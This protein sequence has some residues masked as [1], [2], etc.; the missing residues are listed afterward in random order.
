M[1]ELYN[2]VEKEEFLNTIEVEE[3]KPI[4]YYL[5]LRAKGAEMLYQK[6]L[7]SFSVE[8]IEDVMRNVNPATLNSAANTKS[9]INNY[10]T[11]AIRNGRRANN[12]NPVHG[13]TRE[14]ERKF[15]D[16]TAKRHLSDVEMTDLVDSLNNA[17]DQALVQCIYEGILG[18]YFSE[19]LSLR[20]S[21]INWNNNIVTVYDSK[22]GKER[23]VKVSDRCMKFIKNA[24]N[25]DM[26][27]PEGTE[28]ER[29]LV[30]VDDFVFKNTKWRSS[31]Y[32]RPNKSTLFKRIYAIKE[33][34]NLEEFSAQVINEAG[35]IKMATEI[36][37]ER[38]KLEKEEF[39]MIG[40]QYS[41][42]LVKIGEYEY[43][44]ISKMKTYINERNFK[45]LY[46]MDAKFE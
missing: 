3:V 6:D 42:P 36:Y 2:Q 39:T 19:I 14:W 33:Y 32:N 10:I 4:Y 22:D 7:Y 23:D 1:E 34:H 40:D 29:E 37:K 12:I 15:I 31:R 38:G 8:Q 9:R 35:R 11:W 20:Y 13:L 28:I 41:L 18:Q 30:M 27:M 26:Y 45:E 21:K 16:S 46:D 24:Y 5:F 44:D 17:Q 25:Q 43:Y